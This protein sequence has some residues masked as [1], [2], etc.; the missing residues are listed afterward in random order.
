MEKTYEVKGMSCVICKN[1][2]EKGLEKLDGV[3]SCRVNLLENEATIVFDEQIV[4]EEMLASETKKLGYELVLRRND[5]D[6]SFIRLVISI[7]L[8]V[9][10]M[11]ISMTSM[12]NPQK[13]MY[14]QL[15]ISLA[16]II[17]NIHFY[18]SGLNALFHLKPN[19]D[20]LVSL[21]SLVS[22]IYSLWAIYKISNGISY[23]LYFETAAMVLTVV[24]LGK[25]IE[26][27][28][29]KKTVKIIRGLSTLIPMQANLVTDDGV[30]ITPI[31]NIKK[32]DIVL[33]KPGESVPQ[34]GIILKGSSSL[35][36]SMITGEA[37]PISKTVND[38]VI[39]GTININ[40]ELTVRVSKNATQTVLA[41][42]ISLT[43]QATMTKIPIERFA[44]TIANYF[45]YGILILSLITFIIWQ[46]SAKDLELSLNFALSVLVIACPCALGLATPSAIMVASGVS[47]KN[48]VLI[49]NP[50]ILEIA[51]KIKNIIIDKTGTLTI[52]KLK[53]E[54]YREYDSELLKAVSS[55]EKNSNHPIAKAISE[56]FKNDSL[57]FDRTEEISGEG[58]VGYLG[59]DVYFAGNIDMASKHNVEVNEDDLS[60][61]R[62]H[63]CSY[64]VVGKNDMLLGVIYLSD[65]VKRTSLEAIENMKKRDINPIMA[66]GDNE[67]SARIVSNKLNIEEYHYGV[68][69]KDKNSLI[70]EKKKEGI[71]SMVGDGI[72]DAV[73][74]GSADVSFSLGNASDIASAASDVI[75]LKDDLNDIPFVYDLSKKTIRIIKQNLFWALFYNAIFIPLAAGVFYLPFGIKLSPIIGA[76]TM[77]I[78]SIFVLSN[79][80]RINKVKKEERITMNKI[81]TIE[82]MMC[83][84]CK[85]R[86]EDALKA[87][88]A[89]VEIDLEKGKAFIKNCDISDDVLK[90]T[91]ENTG[92]T[93]VDIKEGN[94]ESDSWL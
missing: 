54:S 16:I 26:G 70:V 24:S 50:A 59:D 94:E 35:D 43:K 5:V 28:N 41:N 51:H 44:D 39:G 73:A 85:K 40:G 93:L 13:T 11:V 34:D 45:V 84:H 27:K 64:I 38:E 9:I 56:R 21:S 81:L 63:N 12:H 66:T 83:E 31:E 89:D 14:Y 32:D 82:G 17:I 57:S 65:I 8:T 42:I 78:S 88:G 20:S 79:A 62:E 29:K 61:A 3:S 86:M 55:L 4:T 33:I 71:V 2:V 1:T 6:Y 80:L 15:F 23:H 49:K 91:V 74:L 25:Y 76:I 77:S 68:K 46:I 19:M 67:I 75:L 90:A 69:P 52:N 37:L 30:I 58:I 10:L 48:G 92:Y 22:F 60:Y 72:N 87:L 7:A 18:R 53:V 36:E 47:A